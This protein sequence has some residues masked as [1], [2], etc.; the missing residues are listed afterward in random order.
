VAIV[1]ILTMIAYPAYQQY[2]IRAN[3]AEAKAL[4]MDLAQKEQLY[5]TD[6]RTYTGT[7]SVI[8]STLPARVDENYLVAIDIT[9]VSPVPV[10]TITASPRAGTLQA[11]DGNLTIDQS[12]QKFH[13]TDPW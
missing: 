10:F 8:L 12:G 7:V 13:G 5:Y 3:R 2:L 1:A 4:L 9:T 11:G 6:T